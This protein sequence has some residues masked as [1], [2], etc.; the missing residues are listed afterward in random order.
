MVAQ[1]RVHPIVPVVAAL[2]GWAV[3]MLDRVKARGTPEP[4]DLLNQPA[5]VETLRPHTQRIRILTLGS[6]LAATAMNAIIAVETLPYPLFAALYLTQPSLI[7]IF[8]RCTPQGRL[9]L[10]HGD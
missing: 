3:F 6:I 8:W 4:N 2:I 10:L 1:L 9:L 7:Q 5:R